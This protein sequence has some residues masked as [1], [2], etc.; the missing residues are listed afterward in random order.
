MTSRL[1]PPLKNL[2]TATAAENNTRVEIPVDDDPLTPGVLS[3][4]SFAWESTVRMQNSQTTTGGQQ[5]K[6]RAN[7]KKQKTHH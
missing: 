5:H 2:P 1:L 3:S 7:I 6:K 4:D